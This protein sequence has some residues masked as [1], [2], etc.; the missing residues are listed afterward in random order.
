MEAVLLKS[1]MV[2]SLSDH[3]FERLQTDILN[4]TLA[5]GEKL[6]EQRVCDEYAVSRTPVR[7]AFRLLERSGLIETIPNRGAFVVGFSRQDS[8]DMYELRKAYEVLAVRWAILRMTDEERAALAEAYEFMEFYTKKGDGGKMLAINMNFHQ[9]IYNGSHNR[10]LAN[11]LS[12]YQVYT[13]ET[14][15]GRTYTKKGLNE[16]LAEHRQIYEAFRNRDPQAGETAMI[17]H[18][19]HAKQRAQ[20]ERT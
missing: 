7:E 4:G 11:V 1:P 9:L 15:G 6:T 20:N 17:T 18:L 5:P 13:Q 8:E 2:P 12:M 3:L 19:E 14:R 16:V 10:M